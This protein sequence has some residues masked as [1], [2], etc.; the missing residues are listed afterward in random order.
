M[1]GGL[2]GRYDADELDVPAVFLLV[3]R[4]MRD[5]KKQRTVYLAKRLP[6]LLDAF[7]AVV[8]NQAERIRENTQAVS[9]LNRCFS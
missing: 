7:D 2:A 5:Q 1:S 3:P 4:H 6:A 8:F 9:K